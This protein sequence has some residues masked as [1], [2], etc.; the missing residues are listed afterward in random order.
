M[1]VQPISI[2]ANTISA[3]LDRTIDF[4]DADVILKTQLI[5]DALIES[6]N[7][8][9]L[10]LESYKGK[11]FYSWYR[12]ALDSNNTILEPD[13]M[14]QG[15]HVMP[16]PISGSQGPITMENQSDSMRPLFINPDIVNAII[17]YDKGVSILNTIPELKNPLMFVLNTLFDG[18]CK[19]DSSLCTQ[20]DPSRISL[21]SFGALTLPANKIRNAFK[22]EVEMIGSTCGSI[23]PPMIASTTWVQNWWEGFVNANDIVSPYA[24][25]ALFPG[26]SFNGGEG[27]DSNT[28]GYYTQVEGGDSPY[29]VY[30]NL[31]LASWLAPEDYRY[32]STVASGALNINVKKDYLRDIFLHRIGA[33][34]NPNQVKIA[35]YYGQTY[36]SGDETQASTDYAINRVPIAIRTYNLN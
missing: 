30:G 23:L 32:L 17:D 19:M 5:I 27:Q 9:A 4:T 1:L 15:A 6:V 18:V 10:N 7:R 35:V 33:S 22:C 12:V 28:C 11:D 21:N 2:I 14:A 3:Y 13:S 20:Y 29:S 24:S 34:K 31:N 8:G 25:N 36:L 16:T 26:W